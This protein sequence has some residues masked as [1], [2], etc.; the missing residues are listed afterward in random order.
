[1]NLPV[2]AGIRQIARSGDVLRAWHMF[3]GAG[4]LSS[5][6][7]EALSLKGRLLKDRGLAAHGQDRFTLLEAAQAAYVEA[8]GERRATYPLINAATIAL[9]SGKPKEAKAIAQRVLDLLDS[10]DHQPETRYWLGA[11]AAEAYLLLGDTRQARAALE[12][13]VTAAP[14]AWEDHAATLRQFQ[15]ILEW[16]NGPEGFFDDLRPPPSLYF[17]GI[18]G[19]PGDEQHVRREIGAVIER[20]RPGIVFGAL[21]AGADIVIAEVA[22]ENGAQLHVVLPAPIDVF[23][24]VSVAQFG[25]EWAQRFDRLIEQAEAIDTTQGPQN[26][27]RAAVHLGAQMAMGLAIRR[28]RVLASDALAFHVGRPFDALPLPE[29]EWRRHGRTLHE[30]A[31][32]QSP[33]PGGDA[34]APGSIRATLALRGEVP[35]GCALNFIT[36]SAEVDGCTILRFED[37]V[38]AMDQA[39]AILRAAPDASMGLDYR[40]VDPQTPCQL[41]D[42]AA[43]ILARSTQEGSVCAS[44]PEIAVLELLAP[45][46]RFETAGE[47]ITPE[48]DIPVGMFLRESMA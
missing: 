22:Q 5:T 8:A 48:G 30:L 33:L 16:T 40:P 31:L 32:E 19:L 37:P 10:G 46:Y 12:Q 29:V 9:M 34:L 43:I 25:E 4:L 14:G 1:M 3:E 24:A 27:S 2:L 38:A 47:V 45:H 26:L 7:P 36:G 17:S 39:T 44:W 18:I 35:R 21:A 13:A 23:R 41:S 11:T 15:Q 20:L 6:D 28:A 42:R